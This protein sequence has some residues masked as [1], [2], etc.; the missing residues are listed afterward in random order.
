MSSDIINGMAEGLIGS[1]F[2]SG[3]GVL[4][5]FAIAKVW[6]KNNKVYMMQSVW[7]PIFIGAVGYVILYT[8][9][10]K[11]FAG[12]ALV[13]GWFWAYSSFKN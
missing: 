6:N 5:F 7:V 9:G 11:A 3:I 1:I 12:L 8:I 10:Y 13:L 2:F 4:I